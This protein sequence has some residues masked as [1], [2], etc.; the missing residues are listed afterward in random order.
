[1]RKSCSTCRETFVFSKKQRQKHRRRCTY[2]AINVAYE[3]LNRSDG[4]QTTITVFRQPDGLFSCFRCYEAF[5]DSKL[6]NVRDRISIKFW[7]SYFIWFCRNIHGNAVRSSTFSPKRAFAAY[8]L[9]RFL[10]HAAPRL[11]CKGV[12]PPRRPCTLTLESRRGFQ[13]EIISR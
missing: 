6:F 4:K 5:D 8:L 13:A 11:R 12:P 3:D 10:P 1:M 2:P 9:P 7:Y